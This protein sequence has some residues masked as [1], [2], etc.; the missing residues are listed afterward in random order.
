M[1]SSKAIAALLLSLGSQ[2][3]LGQ[4]ALW[5]QC[6]GQGYTGGTTC[7]SGACCSAQNQWYSQCL[8]GSCNPS[9]GGGSPAPT[10]TPAPSTGGT[11]SPGCGKNPL[12]SG[13]RSVNVNGK[14]RQYIIR[15]PNGYD[16]NKAYKLIFGFHWRGGSMNDVASG[17]TDKEAW[18][19]YGMQRVGQ[20]SAILVAPHGLNGGWGN[21]GGEDIAFV[22]AMIA[23]IE[24]GLCVD[25][26]QR[27]A[28]GFSWGGAM[29]YSIACS[30]AKVFRGVAVI[31]GGV[32]SGCSGGGDPIAYMGIHGV[33]DNVLGIDGGRGLRDKFVANNGCT[34]INPREPAAGSKGHVKTEYTGCKAGYPVTWIAFDGGHYPGAV[35]GQGESG[36]KSYVPGEIFSFFSKLT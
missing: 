27:Y 16:S 25:Q 21:A 17:G 2:V 31:S 19:Y 12:A 26:G 30:R 8:P 29:S 22:D 32:L 15:V 13:T 5:G 9:N 14:N 36:A 6:G 35:D 7:V 24:A 33:S 20:E 10:T 1:V 23:D 11:K 4:V 28:I 34:K 3:A 18:A